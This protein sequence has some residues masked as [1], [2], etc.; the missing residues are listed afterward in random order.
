MFV[1][2]PTM[3]TVLIVD[4]QVE[5]G[6]VLSRILQYLGHNPIHV[7]SGEDALA[8]IQKH[9]PDAVLLDY[10][11]PGMDGLTVLKTL[12]MQPGTERLPVILFTAN[13]DAE[14]R[15]SAIEQGA[16]DYWVKSVIGM[17][18]IETRLSRWLQKEPSRSP[19]AA[20]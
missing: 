16:N 1:T 20:N 19:S 15:K 5:T 10:M 3:A 4:D 2:D 8:Y 14:V 12:R 18:E 11:M 7:P 17:A 9:T 13:S 6:R